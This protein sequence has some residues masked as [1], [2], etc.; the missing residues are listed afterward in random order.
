MEAY[1]SQEQ[2]AITRHPGLTYLAP[3][4]NGRNG[5]HQNQALHERYCLQAHDQYI[6]RLAPCTI[7]RSDYKNYHYIA[8]LRCS[9]RHNAQY[10]TV[11]LHLA[12]AYTNAS[13]SLAPMPAQVMLA[14]LDS[15]E[16]ELPRCPVSIQN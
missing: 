2:F 12:K 7:L 1:Q 15:M 5:R 8:C 4:M 10:W 16:V 14:S 6:L 3:T 13:D 9:Y 11:L